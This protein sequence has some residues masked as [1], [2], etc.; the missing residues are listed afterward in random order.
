[1]SSIHNAAELFPDY[2]ASPKHRARNRMAV[3]AAG[4]WVVDEAFRQRLAEPDRKPVLFTAGGTAS[5]K[6]TAIAS[7][8]KVDAIVFDNTFSNYATSR[9]R[10]QE[11]LDAGRQV[12][13]A[14]VYQDPLKAWDLAKLRAGNEGA[15]RQVSIP[16]H[17]FSHENAARTVARLAEEYTGNSALRFLFFDNSGEMPIQ[18]T[19]ELTRRGDY[20]QLGDRL[21]QLERERATVGPATP[22]GRSGET[23]G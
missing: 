10:L 11:A 21:E 15:G 8:A 23:I 17:V 20:T 13:V 4:G 9:R 14:Y 5:G 22:G 6:S 3:A 12:R 18:G 2:S 7:V 16:Y 19:I 1:M